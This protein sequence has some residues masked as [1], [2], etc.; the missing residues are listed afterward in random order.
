[1]KTK[2]A[3]GKVVIQYI[4]FFHCREND[5]GQLFDKLKCK[6]EILSEGYFPRATNVAI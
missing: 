6:V 2:T 1:M 5:S 4:N 3:S